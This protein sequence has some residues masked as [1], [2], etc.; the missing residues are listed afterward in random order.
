M[1]WNLLAGFGVAPDA[2]GLVAHPESAERRDFDGFAFDQCVGHMA[3]NAFN[4][5]RGFIAAQAY[6]A[7]YCFA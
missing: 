2:G 5:L 4:Q 6:F 3:Q 1:D 7:K